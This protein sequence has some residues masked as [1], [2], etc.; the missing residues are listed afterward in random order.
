MAEW[1]NANGNIENAHM[2]NKPKTLANP[3]LTTGFEG[4]D[5]RKQ[6]HAQQYYSWGSYVFLDSITCV[7]AFIRQL[8]GPPTRCG[9]LRHPRS[10]AR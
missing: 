10:F 4:W 1:T 9:R 6:I 8:P 2:T 7:I 5:G 3:A